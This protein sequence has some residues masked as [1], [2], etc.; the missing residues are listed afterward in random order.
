MVICVQKDMTLKANVCYTLGVAWSYAK[1]GTASIGFQPGPDGKVANDAFAVRTFRLN[2]P[3]G[4]GQFCADRDGSATVTVSALNAQG[5]MAINE[6]LEYAVAIA[7]KPETPDE[8][9]ARRQ[10][11]SQQ[12]AART[13]EIQ[14]NIAVA[15]AR[16]KANLEQRCKECRENF[17]ACQVQTAWDRQHPQPGVHY[18]TTCE[19]QFRLCS[20]GGIGREFD[21]QRHPEEKPCGDPPP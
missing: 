3:G 10:S 11:E 15:E 20:F 19:S 13:A 18:T 7:A 9:K 6:S 8:T 1:N 14:T 2:A 5:A 16:E 17:R 21:A 12:A 4:S